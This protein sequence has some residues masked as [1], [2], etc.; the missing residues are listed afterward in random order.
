MLQVIDSSPASREGRPWVK[1]KYDGSTRFPGVRRGL[2]YPIADTAK[3]GLFSG[4]VQ[5]PV[6]NRRCW[7]GDVVSDHQYTI[8]HVS[9]RGHRESNPELGVEGYIRLAQLRNNGPKSY[10]QGI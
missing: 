5:A 8:F 2:S 3:S 10:F 6:Y 1:Y 7:A 9:T 4:S